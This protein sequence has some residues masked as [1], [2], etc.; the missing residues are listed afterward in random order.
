M[1]AHEFTSTI[2]GDGFDV[3]V[4]VMVTGETIGPDV[5]D[6]ATQAQELAA[7]IARKGRNTDHGM[8]PFR[9]VTELTGVDE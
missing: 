6:V 5:Y 3:T 9:G 4:A 1:R 7:T 8:G 2:A